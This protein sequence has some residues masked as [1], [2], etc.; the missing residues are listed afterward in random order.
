VSEGATLVKALLHPSRARFDVQRG[1]G[2][3]DSNLADTQL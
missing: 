3:S 1:G 2:G